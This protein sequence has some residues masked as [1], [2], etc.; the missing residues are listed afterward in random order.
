M[1]NDSRIAREF[2]EAGLSAS[3]PVID[4]HGHFGPYQ[5]IYFPTT[6]AE[7]MIASMD[8]AGVRMIVCSSHSSLIEPARGNPEME[9]VVEAHPDRFRAYWSV[10]P[11]YVDTLEQDLAALEKRTAF[12]G[13]K[14]LSDY[15]RYP[16]TGERYAPALEYAN[17]RRFPV[18]MHTWGGSQYDSAT[19]V[20]E[21]A[22]KYPDKPILMGHS[23]YGAWDEAIATAHAHENVYLEL[24]AAYHVNG[25]IARM[26]AEAGSHKILFGT[27]LPWFDQ[28]YGI[29]GV[30]FAK[31][32]DD[33]RHNILHRNAERLFGVAV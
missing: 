31:I 23:S 21:V 15:H 24:C 30:A 33:D 10:N 2:V 20:A 3:C 7:E 26:V 5:G 25:L 11:H 32:S 27:D 28:H 12:A 22:A 13:L 18:L 16:I 8:R 14:F 4:S 9:A 17:A 1:T 29:G 19:L 6:T